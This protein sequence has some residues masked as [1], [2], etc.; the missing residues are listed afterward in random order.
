MNVF[1]KIKELEQVAAYSK[2]DRLVQGIINTINE[3][4]L[5]PD[6]TLPS[7]NT[8]I[9][10]LGFSRETIM[11]GYREL[12][13]RGIVESKNRLGYYVANGGTGQLLKVALMMYN[14]DSFEEQ[15]YRNFRNT[16]GE[17]ISL[18]V[19]F[20]HGNIDV[21]ET[22]LQRIK[23]QF[24]MYVIAPIPHPKSKELLE[25]IPANKLLMFD[26]FEPLE[27]EVNHITQEFEKSSYSV[28]T[29]LADEIKRFDEFIFYHTPDSLDPKEIVRAFQKFL[30]THKVNGRIIREFVPGTV[31]KNKVYFTLDN[32]AMWQILKEC[33]A[34]K[35]KPGKDVGLLSH[36]DEPAKEFVG[37][38]TY[39]A[40]FALMGTIAAQTIL[41][42]EKVQITVPTTLARRST[43]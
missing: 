9:R 4:I 24:G 20:H 13:S 28:F 35:L 31:E 25:S 23:G 33:K 17:G 5:L 34:K 11:K 21:F 22:I 38:T 40:N 27:G 18:Q 29:E 1:D 30:K 41:S 14:L 12:V 6:D 8:M 15:F 3:E 43:L 2:H 36:N 42:K 16:L 7:V 19:F 37:V 26:R 10:E 32:F 39:S